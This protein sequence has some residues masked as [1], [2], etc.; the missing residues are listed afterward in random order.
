M[1]EEQYLLLWKGRQIGPFNAGQIR[2]KLSAGDINRMH[3]INVGGRWQ[4]LDDYLEKLRGTESEVR[5]AEQQEAREAEIKRQFEARSNEE[6]ARPGE[7]RSALSH[8][9]PRDASPPP[10]FQPGSALPA[11]SPFGK[12]HD[13]PGSEAPHPP[14]PVSQS[15]TNGFAIAALVMG[16][17]SFIPFVDFVSW[18]LALVFGHIAL[19]Q[20]KGDESIKGRGM[21]ITGLAITYFFLVVVITFVVLCLANN[22][23]LPIRF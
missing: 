2:E 17:C 18:I 8:L 15:R 9:I 3:Q 16:L 21:A 6:S 5:R 11:G 20:M 13:P 19:T 10:P 23:P 14:F 1:A 4:I 22:K 7:E 12:F